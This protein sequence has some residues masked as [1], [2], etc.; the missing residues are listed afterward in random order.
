MRANRLLSILIIISQKR[1][2]TG[3]ELAEHFEVSL[4]TIYRDIEK[5]SEAGVPIAAIG[6]KGGGYYIMENY[7]LNNIFLNKK[8]IEPL[9]A[10]VDNLKV[11]FGSNPQFNDIVNKFET[12]KNVNEL[13]TSKL[14]INMS[15]LNMEQD[16]KEYLFLIN[17]GIEESKLLEFGYI[18]R[19]VSYSNRIVEPIQIE[20]MEGQWY[21][22]GFCRSRKDYRK[23]KLVR[24]KDLKLGGTFIKQEISQS[25]IKN[26][27]CE[28]LQNGSELVTLKFSREIGNQLV[29][30]FPKEAIRFLED[31]TYIVEKFFPYDE[32]LKRFI[33]G[34]GN[35]C[36]VIS[37]KKL[38][39]EMKEYI[40]IIYNKYNG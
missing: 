27:F 11:L 31:G 30:Y 20:F 35:Y 7:I 37:P 34:F 5:I 10:V 39:E 17:K 13:E 21:I 32:G 19:K 38:K 24:I 4:R 40:K 1:L 3:K 36:E 33:L 8:E 2:I 22:I 6:G 12:L 29:E 14:I 9:I 28:N 16:L 25:E 18:N 15:H 23:F 26:I